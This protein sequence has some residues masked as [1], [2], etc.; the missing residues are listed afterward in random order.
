MGRC[1]RRLTFYT[2]RYATR[3]FLRT[4]QQPQS[5]RRLAGLLGYNPRPG[6]A[7][8][9]E[10][11]F[12]ADPGKTIQVPVG[13][14]V[15]SAP[16]P[17]QQPQT[18]ETIEAATVDSR[19]NRLRIYPSRSALNA[20]EVRDCGIHV[21]A[22]AGPADSRRIWRPTIRLSSSITSARRR[23][24]RRR[25]SRSDVEDD[26]VILAWTQPVQANT[27]SHFSAAFK[28]KR[29][30]QLF[31]YNAQT[32]WFHAVSEQS[33]PGGIGWKFDNLDFSVPAATG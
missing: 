19:F 22:A 1:L 28:F 3:C 20:L 16:A 21:V 32:P 13:L 2:E 24:K 5:L 17:N 7:A 9:A 33:V 6:V 29:K 10:L 18:F 23:L 8:L 11:A 14:R 30:I 25:S 12:T 26:R 15:Q 31:G 4:A 27:W